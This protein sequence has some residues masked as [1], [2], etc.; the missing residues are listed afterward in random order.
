MLLARLFQVWQRKFLTFNAIK[1]ELYLNIILACLSFIGGCV[2]I[3]LDVIAYT[4]ATFFIFLAFS[5]YTFDAYLCYRIHRQC[6]AQTQT[7]PQ[8]A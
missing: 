4:I 1:Y 7:Q 6:D 8:I 5:F 2:S 3:S